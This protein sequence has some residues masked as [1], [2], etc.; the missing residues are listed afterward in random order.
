MRVLRLA[1]GIICAGLGLL[2]F[3]TPQL[4]T[5]V[6]RESFLRV[7]EED[8]ETAGDLY[9]KMEAYNKRLYEEEDCSRPAYEELSA[10]AAEEAVGTISIPD[11]DVQL[12][13]F[14]GASYEHLDKGAAV[15]GG[16][17]M[18]VGGEN[19]NC[20]ILGHRSWCGA[21][22][23]RDIDAMK[24]G[25][26]VLIDNGKELLYYEAFERE[27]ILPDDRSALRIRPGEDLV[28]LITC[29][30][31]LGG[32]THRYVVYCRRSVYDPDMKAQRKSADAELPQARTEPVQVL[33]GE[34]AGYIEEEFYEPDTAG[35]MQAE[36]TI[37]TAA[38]FLLI[39]VSIIVVCKKL[40]DIVC[41]RHMNEN[42]SKT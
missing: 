35:L 17:S 42:N 38:C 20:V 37:R 2:F 4:K 11:M 3:L 6:I 14:I 5:A 15:L 27:I 41:K 25:S 9:E 22:Y 34:T 12:P 31:Y 7:Q 8:R 24:E 18:P 29:H 28:T 33:P 26:L 40:S 36:S 21:P 19:S 30:P 23:F 13:L 1:A 10:A 16:S 32:G 39:F